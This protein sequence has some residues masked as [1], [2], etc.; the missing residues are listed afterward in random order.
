MI[1]VRAAAVTVDPNGAPAG[2]L[3]SAEC[4]I[5]FVE[6]LGDLVKLHLLDGRR[7]HARQG[8]RRAVPGA[9]AAV[10]ASAS[11]SRGR[12]RMSS[13]STPEPARRRRSCQA[14]ARRGRGGRGDPRP[15]AAEGGAC[16]RRGRRRPTRRRRLGDGRAGGARAALDRL[17]PRRAAR[18]HRPRQ[19][20]DVH[21]LRLRAHVDA[22]QLQRA[23]QR[24]RPTGTTCSRRSSRR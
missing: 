21:R 12:R 23:V 18:D 1:A 16:A 9:C 20:L 14:R 15:A 8:R 24:P 7:A 13:S 5:V 19:L 22:G 4:E 10:R 3:N 17:L 11:G 6:F 2:G